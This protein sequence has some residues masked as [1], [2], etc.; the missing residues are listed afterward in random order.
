MS[1]TL[2][3]ILANQNNYIGLAFC[4]EQYS[5]PWCMRTQ[6]FRHCNSYCTFTRRCG[7][8]S[9]SLHRRYGYLDSSFWIG[10]GHSASPPATPLMGALS[11]EQSHSAL[12][13]TPLYISSGKKNIHLYV[14]SMIEN[15]KENNIMTKIEKIFSWL[16]IGAVAA[17]APTFVHLHQQNRL[18]PLHLLNYCIFAR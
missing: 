18:P 6:K 5:E 7:T 1:P 11:Q 2:S 14:S 10:L 15:E 12:G 16:T 3:G 8:S 9:S 4:D 17:N 13:A